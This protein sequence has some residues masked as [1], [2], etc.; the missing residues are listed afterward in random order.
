MWSLMDDLSLNQLKSLTKL[1]REQFP[2]LYRG[3]WIAIFGKYCSSAELCSVQRLFCVKKE[4]ISCR[5]KRGSL[6]PLN[7]ESVIFKGNFGL[8]DLTN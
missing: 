8:W 3:K 7:F 4:T 2:A 1:K 5:A 6:T